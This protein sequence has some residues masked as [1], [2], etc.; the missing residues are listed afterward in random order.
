MQ[1]TGTTSV[2][3]FFRD[4]N[5]KVAGWELDKKNQWSYL[6][7]IGDFESIFKSSDFKNNQVFEDSPWWYPEFY[8]VLYHRF[9]NSKFILFTRD[10]ENWFKSMK[11]HSKGKTLGNTKKHC[12]IYRREADFYNL[13][14]DYIKNYNESKVDNLLSLEGYEKHYRDLYEIRNKEVIDFFKKHDPNALFVD[15]LE[16]DDKWKKLASFCG[17]EIS[18]DYKV[19]MNKSNNK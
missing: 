7:N 11:F 8:K 4:F 1:R 17:I 15:R 3:Q 10:S 16:N 13:P 18:K 14:S 9:P 6:W 2:G 5:Y 12:K 19:H